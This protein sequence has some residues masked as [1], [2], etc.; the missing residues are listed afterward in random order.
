M[1]R[2]AHIHALLDR[3]DFCWNFVGESAARL[4]QSIIGDYERWQSV[5]ASQS[6]LIRRQGQLIYELRAQHVKATTALAGIRATCDE[7]SHGYAALAARFQTTS[8]QTD[9]ELKNDWMVCLGDIGPSGA[10]D[11]LC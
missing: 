8:P 6:E 1:L 3:R 10:A 4:A 11:G 7:L 9:V 5:I 2:V